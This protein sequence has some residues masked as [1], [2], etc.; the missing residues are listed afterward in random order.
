MSH[1][2][3]SPDAAH[4]GPGWVPRSR[5]SFEEIGKLWGACG[6]NSEYAK[7][8]RVAMYRPGTELNDI[9]DAAGAHWRATLNLDVARKQFDLLQETYFRHGVEVLE[10]SPIEKPTPNLMFMRDLFAM[11]R[12]GAILARPASDVRAGE[13]VIVSRFLAEHNIPVLLSVSGKGV[14]EGP[15]FM[16]F[17]THSAFI[18]TGIRTNNE[19]ARQVSLALEIQGVEVIPIQTTYGCGHLDGVLSI[20]GHKKAVLYPTRVS[21][22]V[23]ETLRSRGYSIIHLPDF[24][25]AEKCM[26]INMVALEPDLVLITEQSYKT[27]EA[28]RDNSVSTVCLNLSELMKAGG[29]MHCL[30]GVIQRAIL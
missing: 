6:Q 12:I 17:D 10:V 5:S 19:G 20:V 2:D 9:S 14:F 11:T 27:R 3:C 21:Y 1:Q 26:A 15:D 8:L 29:A 25:E 22:K 7:L 18:G 24:A 4:G 13:E 23:F 16:F 28:L 30:T